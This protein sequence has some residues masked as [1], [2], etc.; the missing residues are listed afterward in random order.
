MARVF[1][2]VR[3]VGPGRNAELA[4][5]GDEAEG[6]DAIEMGGAGCA[7]FFLK[8]AELD[9][10]ADALGGGF[11]VAV[12]HGGVG[13]DAQLV[14]G[15]MDFEP[16]VVADFALEDFIVDAVVEDF[17]AAAGQAAEAGLAQGER[18]FRGRSG[19]RPG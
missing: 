15:A 6:D 17:R 11:D 9:Q 14:G 3:P 16:A 18:A 1:R 5:F 13:I 10:V 8:L 19:G 12:E 2:S 7:G 4:V